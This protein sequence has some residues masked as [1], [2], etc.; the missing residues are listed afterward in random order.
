M[1]DEATDAAHAGSIWLRPARSGRGPAPGFDRDRLAAAGIAIA[2]A[3]G[4]GAVTMRAVAQAL[5]SGPASLYRYIDS[6]DELLALMADFV[7]GEM[8]YPARTGDWFADLLA[9]ARQSRLLT[10]RHPWMTETAALRLPLGPRG[11]DYL[12]HALAALEGAPADA[13]AKLEAIGLLN[14]VV[15]ALARAEIDRAAAGE[16]IPQWQ[17]AQQVFLVSAA[18]DGDHPH[19]AA[20]LAEAGPVPGRE[21]PEA[22]FERMVG[23]V[24]A[25]LLRAAR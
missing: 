6:R 5:G 22:L 3:E 17:R 10:L 11:V 20:T 16:T 12:E 8:E 25:G 9:L 21:A 7:N 1:P 24:L 15:T 14:A 19:L 2:D 18:M 13:Q 23:R 4:L